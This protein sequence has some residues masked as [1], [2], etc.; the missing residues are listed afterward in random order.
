MVSPNR[1]FGFGCLK[2]CKIFE[3]FH[4]LSNSLEFHI[5][6]IILY[7][8]ILISQELDIALY[9]VEICFCFKPIY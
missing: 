3:I 6:Q 4:I 7:N 1:I 9:G 8:V 2:V 5:R